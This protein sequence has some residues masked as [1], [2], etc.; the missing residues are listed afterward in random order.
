MRLGEVVAIPTETVYGLAARID[1][2]DAIKNIF[3]LKERPLFD[4]LIVHVARFSQVSAV[5]ESLT[6]AE[7]ALARGIWPGPLTLVVKRRPDLNPMIC[8][9]LES[10]GIRCPKHPFARRL[11]DRAGAPLAAPS[12]NKFSRTSPT[13]V[14]HVRSFWNEAELMIVDGGPCQ[15]GIESAVVRL[16]E[17]A[18]GKIQLEILR[19]GSISDLALS[20]P[21]IAAGFEVTVSRTQDSS[22][23]G[24]LADH[25]RPGIP[26][27]L[28]PSGILPLASERVEWIA[29]ALGVADLRYR[30][31][32]LDFSPQLAAR[33]LYSEL[34]RLSDTDNGFLVFEDSV[35]KQAP[36]WDALW[37]R[38]RRAA[39]LDLRT[40]RE[41]SCP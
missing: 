13:Q 7:E 12:A 40:N 15:V 32:E 4:P 31:L 20:A 28:L 22:S 21:L 3:L 30:A 5:A 37:D 33:E 1:R 41:F 23:P 11:I 26:L 9:G 14:Q 8:S 19:P 25:Y 18:P 36:G 24:Q 16:R 29:S 38:L 17:E 6:R 39:S 2:P 27:V 34:H 35:E 10:V